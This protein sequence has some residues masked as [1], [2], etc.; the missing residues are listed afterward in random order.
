[1]ALVNPLLQDLLKQQS[2]KFG[3]Q[4]L[5]RHRCI[6]LRMVIAAAISASSRFS[7]ALSGGRSIIDCSKMVPN[8]LEL[9]LLRQEM[10][11]RRP[12]G[13]VLPPSYGSGAKALTTLY[14][15]LIL[16]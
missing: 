2:P 15:S 7:G 13:S 1:M 9:L 8:G 4:T 3:R 14:T 6:V 10:P 16:L 11:L 12:N 5:H